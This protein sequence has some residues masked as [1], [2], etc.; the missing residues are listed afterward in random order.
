VVVQGVEGLLL[1][2]R[3]A[4]EVVPAPSRPAAPA[5]AKSNTTRV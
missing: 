4:S 3:R 2:V 1:T 5:V